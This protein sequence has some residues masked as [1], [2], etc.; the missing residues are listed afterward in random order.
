MLGFCSSASLV[1][2]TAKAVLVSNS[3]SQKK[4][5]YITPWEYNS[6]GFGVSFILLKDDDKAEIPDPDNS[7]FSQKTISCL[8]KRSLFLKVVSG[9]N[10]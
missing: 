2:H 4:D 3:C 1:D 5:S 7:S 10:K 6:L 9:I 8:S